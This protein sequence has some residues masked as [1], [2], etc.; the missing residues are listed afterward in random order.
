M[1]TAWVLTIPSTALIAAAAFF[2]LQILS[3]P[4]GWALHLFGV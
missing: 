1:I 3:G 4:I 2:G